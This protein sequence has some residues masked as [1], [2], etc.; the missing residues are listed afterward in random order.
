MSGSGFVYTS[1]SWQGVQQ[2]D[3]QPN[4]Q[5]LNTPLRILGPFAAGANVSYQR[6][7]SFHQYLIL[8]FELIKMGWDSSSVLTIALLDQNNNAVISRNISNT[9]GV[10]SCIKNLI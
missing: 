5:Y 6:S 3:C 9:P 7:V 8:R 2:T 4:S 1:E 10:A